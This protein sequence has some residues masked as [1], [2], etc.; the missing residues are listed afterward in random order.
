MSRSKTR[1][2]YQ[3]QSCGYSSPKWLGKCPD[4]GEWNSFVEEERAVKLRKQETA[5]P[6]KLSEIT[7]STGSRH[8]TQISEFDRALGGGVVLGSV[9]LIGG[10]PGI[11]KSTLLLQA[12]K[13][14][15]KLGD[16]LYV[17]G[18]ESPEQIKI[19]AE[20]LNV[21]SDNIVLLPETS[22]EGII[23]IAQ[24]LSPQVIVIDSIQ[25]VFSLE[26]PSAPGSVAQIR[27]CATKL[28]FFA[29]KYGIP[30]FIIG[31]VTKDGS[32][33]GPR[34]LEH[35]VDTVLYFEGDKG[36]PFRIL[37]AVKN[38][39][40]A[41]NEIGVFEMSESGLKEVDNPSELFLSGR[42]INVPGSVVVA[43][44]EGTRPMIVEIQALVSATSFGVPR[45]T[46]LGVDY[47]RVNLLIAVLDKRLGMRLGDMDIFVNVVGGLKID[48]PAVDMAIISAV[49]SSFKNKPVDPWTFVF[50]E[51]G[52]SG[53][54][55]AISQAETRVKEAAKI[56]LKK[57]VVPAGNAGTLKG[58]DI[59]VIGAKNV[60][61]ALEILFF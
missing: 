28:M 29:K 42:P 16:V 12:L 5:A 47:N 34:V 18:E 31:H 3:C 35:I 46:A 23:S 57:G 50:G 6:V 58:T 26:L 55:R 61:E 54:L 53:E 2:L 25:T 13:G 4:C 38:R 11:G 32:I 44:L 21:K 27:E 33:A 7:H 22:L 15:T 49:A 56:G 24:K 30:L 52:L 39:F 14:L 10:D 20:R 19:R 59:E 17:S 41:A 1:I 8:S 45:R 60:E 36:T 51:I 48:E 43:S 37:R 9:V 40:G